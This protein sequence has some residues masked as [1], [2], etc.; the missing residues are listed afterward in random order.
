MNSRFL[1]RI[2]VGAMGALLLGSSVTTADD[3]TDSIE[4]ALEAYKD[5]DY[6]MATQALETAVQMIKQKKGESLAALLPE[7]P[8]GWEA[9]EAESQAA[10]A[11]MFGGAV[12]AERV[13]RKGEAE[14]SVK[15]VTDSPMLQGIMMM[16]GNP[17]FASANGGKLIRLNGQRAILEHDKDEQSGSLQFTINNVLLVQIEGEGVSADDLKIFGEAVPV[18][19]VAGVL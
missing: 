8:D 2:A 19:K 9:D 4:E 11:A 16:L 1:P 17:M 10:G 7:P 3:V 5:K 15:Y 18:D 13:Y 6:V 14:V 12:T